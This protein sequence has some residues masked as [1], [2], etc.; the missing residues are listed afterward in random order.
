MRALLLLSLAA[1]CTPDNTFT[2]VEDFGGV[3]ES[4]IAGRA[5]DYTRNVWLEGATVYTHI[6]T[7]DGDL[8]GTAEDVTDAEGLWRLENLRNDTT[9]TVYV[10][11]GSEVLDMFDVVVEGTQ[12]VQLPE[13]DCSA[14]TGSVAVISGDYDSLSEVLAAYGVAGAFEVNGT[15]GEELVQFL[16]SADNLAEYDAVL[17]AGGHIEEDVFY[18]TDGTDTEGRVPRVLDAVRSYVE[19]GGRVFATDWSYDVVEQIWPD[20]VDWVGDDNSPNVAQLG[21]PG[22]VRAS[23]R[24]DGMQ[25]AVGA[26]ELQ[27]QFALDTWPI[28]ESAADGVTVY[29]KGDAPW[30]F[31]MEEGITS[32]AP[33]ALSFTAGKGAVVYTSW[34][35]DANAQGTD[36]ENA[37]RYLLSLVAG[38]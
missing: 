34:T 1:G 28:A 7:E 14:G 3:Y 11:Y 37:T 10:Q 21:E 25:E 22:A 32:A 13:P 5:C 26:N 29:Q 16:Q 23:I 20:Q 2:K 31:G 24:D 9:Y 19:S 8:V 6:I 15:T 4:S 35:L 17:F 30:R 27:V 33:L 36:G 18:D 38:E 12:E